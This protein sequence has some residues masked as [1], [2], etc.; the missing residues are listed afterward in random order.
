MMMA[1][2][3]SLTGMATFDPTVRGLLNAFDDPTMIVGGETVELAN[4]AARTL[5]G[6]AIEGSDV[7]LAIRH[8]R[9]LELVF[10]GKPGTIDFTGVG[11][12]GRPWRLDVRSLGK[13]TLL[14]RLIDQ[15]AAHAAEKMRTDFVA[16]ASHEL[17]TPLTAVLGYAESLEEGDLD[18]QLARKFAGTIQTEAKRMLRIIEDLMSLSR[19]EA[20]RFVAPADR[21]SVESVIASSLDTAKRTAESLGCEIQV[22]VEGDLPSVAGD[23][24]QLVQVVDNLLGNALRY[25]C[26]SEGCVVRVAASAEGELVKIAVSD[27]GPG[28]ARA[29]L[30]FLTRRFYRV[31]E[32]RSRESGGTGLG[33][34]IVKHIVERHRGTLTIDSDVGKGTTVT[35]LL[36]AA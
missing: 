34:A 4:E 20:G 8:P 23:F 29:H 14:V 2:S 7:R 13:R 24:P 5:F 25:G 16:N 18:P 31:D 10:S 17:R 11:A 6:D 21:V 32:A 36:P 22:A 35:V 28:I 15:S 12:V 33:L 3:A 26:P 9:A 1:T 27:N 19:I 30:P